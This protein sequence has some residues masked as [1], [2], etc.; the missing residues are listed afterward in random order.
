MKNRRDKF[1]AKHPKGPRVAPTKE[2][3]DQMLRAAKITLNSDQIEQLWKYHQLI[4]KRNTDRELTRIVGFEPMVIKHYIDCMI[5]G[6]FWQFPSPIVD[7]GSGAGFP[8]IPLKILNPSLKMILAEP[9]PKRIEF[10]NEVISELG[11]KDIEV[12]EH[13]VVSRSFTTPVQAVITRAV[14]TMDKTALRTSAALGMGGQLIF[15]KG[16]NA[17]EEIKEMKSRFGSA[18]S[19]TL[20]KAYRLP[21]TDH[22]RRLVIFTRTSE[23]SLQSSEQHPE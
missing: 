20:D 22:Q 3:M 7:V 8:G 1:Y 2:T 9:R 12:F 5:L 15:M 21:D 6:R 4:R 17:D 18:F 23:G 16:P 14:E 19:L 13:K 11:L 10:L